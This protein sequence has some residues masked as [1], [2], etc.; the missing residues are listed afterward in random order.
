ME[1]QGQKRSLREWTNEATLGSSISLPVAHLPKGLEAGRVGAVDADGAVDEGGHQHLLRDERAKDSC[2]CSEAGLG[3]YPHPFLSK[4]Q[5]PTPPNRL[6]QT[7]THQNADE[8]EVAGEA[9]GVHGAGQAEREG[10]PEGAGQNLLDSERNG[11]G[12]VFVGKCGSA[13]TP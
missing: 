2:V 9:Q 5:T 12:D 8:S 1:A 6:C 7:R 10:Q 3:I 13:M 11:G 4:T